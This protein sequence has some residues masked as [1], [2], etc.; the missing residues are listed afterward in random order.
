M[1]K[2]R[3]IILVFLLVVFPFISNAQTKSLQISAYAF[4]PMSSDTEWW[5]NVGEIHIEPTSPEGK[6]R[7]PVFLP[8][9]AIIKKI[10]LRY[11]HDAVAGFTL[12]LYRRNMYTDV[13]QEMT[14][15]ITTQAGSYIWLSTYSIAHKVINNS[16]YC[17][18]LVA[19]FPPATY[20][21]RLAGVKII[22]N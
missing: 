7:A 4:Y 19:D 3:L 5:A 22:Y 6:F 21:A 8:E 18:Y 17:Y 2:N 9:G 1:F 10:L 20:R 11:H 13:E 15:I 14:N 16:G 12:T